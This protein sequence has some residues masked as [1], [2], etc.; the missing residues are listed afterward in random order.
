MQY[1]HLS[2]QW[3]VNLCRALC[4]GVTV[5]DPYGEQRISGRFPGDGV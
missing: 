5:P 4:R 1:F 3:L 2:L